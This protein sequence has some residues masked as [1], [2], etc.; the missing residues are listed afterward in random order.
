MLDHIHLTVY[1]VDPS[2]NHEFHS[3]TPLERFIV[4]TK[5]YVIVF[6]LP[7]YDIASISTGQSGSESSIWGGKF[8][9]PDHAAD[10]ELHQRADQV[11]NLPQIAAVR[12]YFD[13]YLTS[14]RTL[15]YVRDRCHNGDISDDFFVHIFP[16]NRM[17]L[18]DHR[19]QSGFDNLD[20]AFTERGSIDGQRCAAEIELPDYDIAS[21][22][23]GQFTN[24]GQTW[25]SE[26]NA[27]GG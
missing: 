5:R 27:T 6:D 11:I 24:R 18:P 3:F 20:F 9:G 23:T 16:V 10:P 22:S 14:D 12:G 7:D 8:F 17:D 25:R 21:I 26:L 2:Q 4:D 1:P 15:M 13:V 19:R